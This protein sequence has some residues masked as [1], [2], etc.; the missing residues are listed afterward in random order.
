M[1]YIC[2]AILTAGLSTS[3]F[4]ALIRIDFQGTVSL[5]GFSSVIVGNAFTG[6]AYYSSPDVPFATNPTFCGS[7]GACV[8]DSYHMPQAF[9]ITVNGSSIST[10]NLPPAYIQVQD[11]VTAG[12][13]DRVDMNSGAVPLLLSGPIAGERSSAFDSV[14][15]QFAGPTSLFSSTQI[16][17]VFPSL[18]Q[19][20]TQASID[21]A[22]YSSFGSP[23]RQ[24]FG[25]ITSLTST[26]VPEPSTFLSGFFVLFL[27]IR[28]WKN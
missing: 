28:N 13:N 16:P 21:F 8:V 14:L 18:G 19:W 1:R 2:L 24:F 10:T 9:Q 12:P 20:S 17:L 22:T 25:N 6:S 26:V 27:G 5:S 3:A 11:S 7:P 23:D 15:I 4:A